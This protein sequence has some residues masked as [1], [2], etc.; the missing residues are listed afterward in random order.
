M[1]QGLTSLLAPSPKAS[2]NGNWLLNIAGSV[3]H[4]LVENS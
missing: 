1:V 3:V 4:G 2:K